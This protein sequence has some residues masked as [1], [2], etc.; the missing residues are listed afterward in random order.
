MSNPV[1]N[2]SQNAHLNQDLFFGGAD[3][4]TM[5]S[6]AG[7]S[8]DAMIAY[9]EMNLS[10]TDSQIQDLMKQVDQNKDL[11]NELTQVS[12][13]IRGM[14]DQPGRDAQ[15]SNFNQ[16]MQIAK[17][18]GLQVTTNAKGEVTGVVVPPGCTL[19]NAQSI[20]SAFNTEAQKWHSHDKDAKMSDF[21]PG[22]PKDQVSADGG[23]RPDDA[24][25]DEASSFDAL[26]SQLS[27][28]DEI[29]MIKL[30]SLVQDRTRVIQF[31]SNVLNT[32]NDAMKTEVNNI[33]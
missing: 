6:A 32:M 19:P 27:S 5:G 1:S 23:M 25:E 7:L 3:D 2:A 26:G 18:L 21:P 15:A 30:Q 10:S 4:V 22:T 31:A 9:V 11:V 17:Q 28:G 29:S 33:R 13:L 24:L 20:A 16:I 8:P 14:K 12:S